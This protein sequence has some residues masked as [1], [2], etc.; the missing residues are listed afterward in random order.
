MKTFIYILKRNDKPFYVGKSKNW[1]QRF[2]VHKN[3][4]GKDIKIEIIDEVD[5]WRKME[6]HYILLFKSFGAKLTNKNK[7]GGGPLFMSEETK[8]KIRQKSLGRP[9]YFKGK[10]GPNKGRKFGPISEETRKLKSEKSKGRKPT[11]GTVIFKEKYLWKPILQFDY[12]GDLIKEHLSI[13]HASKET[14]IVRVS[15]S[16]VINH[17]TKTAGGFIWLSKSDYESKP[18]LLQ[19][20]LKNNRIFEKFNHKKQ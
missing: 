3:N 4:F 17:K 19:N 1:K 5:D 6:A 12:K 10:V 16:Y 14:G 20:K 2:S 9:G 18:E 11:G 15:I 7:G 8:E 13:E